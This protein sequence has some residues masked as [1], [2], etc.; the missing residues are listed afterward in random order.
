MQQDLAKLDDGPESSRST[1]FG[2]ESVTLRVALIPLYDFNLSDYESTVQRLTEIL[3]ANQ[4]LK[5]QYIVS[6]HGK[7]TFAIEAA[8]LPDFRRDFWEHLV[9]QQRNR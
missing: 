2:P 5:A 9:E 8:K 6:P 4:P 3:F 7:N 1:Y